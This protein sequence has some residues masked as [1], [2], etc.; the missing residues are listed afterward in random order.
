[1]QKKKNIIAGTIIT[2]AVIAAS[3]LGA[4]AQ[5]SDAIRPFHVNVP[6]KKL[7]DLKRRIIATQWPEKETV[8]DQSQG[9]PLVTMQELAHYWATDYDWRKVEAKLNSLPQFV[10]NIDGLDI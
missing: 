7:V 5:S 4:S 6:E 10:T 2:G 1:M 9:V 8:T 3:G